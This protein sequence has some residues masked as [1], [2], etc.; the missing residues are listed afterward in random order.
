MA[1]SSV[2]MMDISMAL[3]STGT[4]KSSP[5]GSVMTGSVYLSTS[6]RSTGTSAPSSSS[7]ELIFKDYKEITDT[8]SAST[9]EESSISTNSKEV[10]NSTVLSSEKSDN[11]QS[12][13]PS[14]NSQ[15]SVVERFPNYSMPL[16]EALRDTISTSSA[17]NIEEELTTH[18]LDT[19]QFSGSAIMKVLR[20]TRKLQKLRLHVLL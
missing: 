17:P 14:F 16:L 15:L 11:S 18:I 4:L 7:L 5:P 1:G 19:P 13:P 8:F 9:T 3:K 20:V 10:N 6:T 2:P 12:E